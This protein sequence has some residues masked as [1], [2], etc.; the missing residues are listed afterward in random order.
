LDLNSVDLH[1]LTINNVF[2]RWQLG[3]TNKKCRDLVDLSSVRKSQE[4]KIIQRLATFTS[5]CDHSMAVQCK[6]KLESIG[7]QQ[8][9]DFAFLDAATINEHFPESEW[10]VVF[11][12][13]LLHLATLVKKNNQI[14]LHANTSTAIVIKAL[15]DTNVE[16]PA[17][18]PT[19]KM[20]I[21][22]GGGYGG[23]GGRASAEEVALQPSESFKNFAD[24][25]HSNDTRELKGLPKVQARALRQYS[26]D[27]S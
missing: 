18:P 4:V 20:A 8:P 2:S 12:N 25:D 21:D 6:K 1:I 22:G 11:R 24:K 16:V 10:S 3:E 19:K 17:F 14:P 15:Q 27:I 23:D 7:I 26:G 5:G 13:K 9:E